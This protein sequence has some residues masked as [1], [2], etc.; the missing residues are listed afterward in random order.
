MEY[1][2]H[3]ET[4]INLQNDRIKVKEDDG[5]HKNDKTDIH[6]INTDLVRRESKSIRLENEMI[7]KGLFHEKNARS[8]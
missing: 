8:L 2:A 7:E 6:N 1:L 4:S 3:K 5:Y